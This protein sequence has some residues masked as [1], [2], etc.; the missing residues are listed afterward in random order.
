MPSEEYELDCRD[1]HK[2][3]VTETFITTEP[4]E[5]TYNQLNDTNKLIYGVDDNPP[6]HMSIL[7][8]LQQILLSLSSTI[9]LAVIVNDQICAKNFPTVRA[10]ILS[11]SLVICGITTLI[12]NT[13][14]VR[15]PILQGG[16]HKFVPAIVALMSLEKWS[17]PVVNVVNSETLNST[18]LNISTINT[19]DPDIVWKIR[20]REIQGGVLLASVVQLMIGCT[21][22]L[23]LIINFVGPLTIMPTI[24]LVGI[25]MFKVALGFTQINWGIAGLTITFMLMFTLYLAKIKIPFFVWTRKKGFRVVHY[26]VFQLLPVILSVILSWSLCA[27]LTYFEV[28]PNDP[29]ELGYGARTDASIQALHNSQWFYVPYPGQWGTPT[30]SFASFLAMMAATFS[31]IIESVG[32]YYASAR[33]SLQPPIPAH[34]I[35]RGIAME[36]VGGILAGAFGSGG[37]VT[38]YSQNVGA[39]GFTKVASRRVFQIAGIMFI[40][41]GVFGKFGAILTMMPAP[42]LGGVI[43]MT[44]GMVISIGL[45]TLQYVD[46]SSNRNHCIIGFS[47]MM[48]LMLPS[49]V[50]NNENSIKTGNNE[51]DQALKVIL[52]TGMFVGGLIG[53][54]LDN[55]V[56]GTA[57]ERGILKW[58]QDASNSGAL[59]GKDSSY[60]LPYVTRWLK[61]QKWSKYIPVLPSYKQ[62][63]NIRCCSRSCK[64]VKH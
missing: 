45:S 32:D 8:S 51:F 4:E 37:G 55:T 30:F 25:S 36:G 17:C 33:I 19:T 39:I 23:G 3:G 40:L 9:T 59:A 29:S 26:Q 54:V 57:E 56:P 10:E 62:V 41:A 2:A 35:N 7:F 43:T 14:G 46:L 53:F 52:S 5:E 22:L 27:I 61:R 58:R 15:V 42:V 60:D 21:G 34:A 47:M 31:S 64:D 38:S 13:V 44:F 48:G 63:V 24:S 20:I 49:W 50:K 16:C 12:Q 18:I 1:G 28:F 11:T 6:I